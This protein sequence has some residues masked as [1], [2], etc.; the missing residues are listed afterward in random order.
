[1]LSHGDTPIYPFG[2]AMSKVQKPEAQTQS[3][4][5]NPKFDLE[6][7]DQRYIRV[8]NVLDTSCYGDRPMC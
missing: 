7:K 6:V 2:M 3:H 1:M 8:M 4:V 5:I